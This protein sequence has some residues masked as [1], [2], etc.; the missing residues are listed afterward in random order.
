[1]T[2]EAEANKALARRFF[3]EVLSGERPELAGEPVAPDS[4]PGARW[5][6]RRRARRG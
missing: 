3:E 4:S 5:C 2:A 1:M 6:P